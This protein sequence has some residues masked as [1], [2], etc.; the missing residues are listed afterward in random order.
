MPREDKM[1]YC[2]NT[3]CQSIPGYPSLMSDYRWVICDDAQVLL[4]LDCADEYEWEDERERKV[5]SHG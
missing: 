3:N 5:L 2:E 4:C 1:P